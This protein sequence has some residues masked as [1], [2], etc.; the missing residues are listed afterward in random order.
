MDGCLTV[1]ILA[2]SLYSPFSWD[3]DHFYNSDNLCRVLP[4]P[5]A[6]YPAAGS[7]T[8]Q[9]RESLFYRAQCTYAFVPQSLL[10]T[11]VLSNRLA[12]EIKV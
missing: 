5:C 12:L 2:R 10:I 4:V 6:L 1:A 7:P 9:H 8:N 11:K 3:I